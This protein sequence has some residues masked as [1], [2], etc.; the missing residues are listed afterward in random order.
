[1]TYIQ[2]D[3]LTRSGLES[4]PVY[5]ESSHETVQSP[6]SKELILDDH[7]HCIASNVF[8]LPLAA[9]VLICPSAFGVGWL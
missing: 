4:S 6:L 2:I 9:L 8:L 1:M 7:I 3:S 5:A